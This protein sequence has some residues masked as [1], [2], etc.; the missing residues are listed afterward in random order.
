LGQES[1]DGG[2]S[3]LLIVDALGFP[4]QH[5]ALFAV[6]RPSE[7][8]RRIQRQTFRGYFRQQL[9]TCVAF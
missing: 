4:A 9:A 5:A 3:S 6:R 8:E 2:S 1:I 7:F